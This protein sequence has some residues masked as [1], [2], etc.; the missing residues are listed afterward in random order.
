V[1]P[2]LQQSLV[3]TLVMAC[4]H[5]YCLNL[6]AMWDGCLRGVTVMWWHHGCLMLCIPANCSI[7][8]CC[9][10]IYLCKVRNPCIAPECCVCSLLIDGAGLFSK[11]IP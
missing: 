7:E 5:V 10:S 9:L 2:N 8:C 11:F 3:V 4:F 6:V 1:I